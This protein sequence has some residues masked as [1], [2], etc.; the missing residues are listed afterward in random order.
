[1]LSVSHAGLIFVFLGYALIQHRPTLYALYCVDNLIFFGAI[2]LTTYLHKIAPQEDL[3]PTLA[4]G[5]TMNHVASVLAPLGGGLAWQFFGYQTIFYSGAVIT[6]VS[7]VLSQWVDP[8]GLL[9][10][11]AAAGR[12]A[13][14]PVPQ[15]V[16]R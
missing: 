16:F 12:T 1:M 6:A 4:M 15:A 2:A 13:G 8:E 14:S 11:E 5:V 9:A 3:K 7:L 10:R